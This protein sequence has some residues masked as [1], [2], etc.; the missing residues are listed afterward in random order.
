MADINPNQDFPKLAKYLCIFLG[1]FDIVLGGLAVFLPRLYAKIFHPD[2]DSPAIDYIV[3]TGLLWLFF[4]VVELRAGFGKPAARWFFLVG[5][6]RL[7]DVPADLAYATLAEG[8]RWWSRA[9]IYAAPVINA[10]SGI[11]LWRISRR[12]K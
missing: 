2:L 4:A 3:R 5:M 7:M 1:F 8:A 6:L 9:M 12:M 11:Y 10:I